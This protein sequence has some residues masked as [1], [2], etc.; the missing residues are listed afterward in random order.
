MALLSQMIRSVAIT[1]RTDSANAWFADRQGGRWAEQTVRSAFP[2]GMSGARRAPRPGAA[3]PA[4]PAARLRELDV[5]RERGV[6]TDA[7]RSRLRA[8]IAV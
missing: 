5:L 7:E 3:A 4:D 8:R 1:G 6:I 2:P